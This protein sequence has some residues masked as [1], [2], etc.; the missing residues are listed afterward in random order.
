M[1]SAS[2][3]FAIA[4]HGPVTAATLRDRLAMPPINAKIEVNLRL[5]EM[6]STVTKGSRLQ[7]WVRLTNN[8][9]I[10]LRSSMPN[11][12]HLSYHCYSER[13][14]E[15]QQLVAFEGI[16]STFATVKAGSADDLEMHLIAPVIEG[17]FLFRITLVQEWVAWFDIPPQSAFVDGWLDVVAN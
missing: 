5:L 15:G 11:P 9:G 8:S 10:D 6:P 2:D 14:L 12:I 1:R 7:A 4:S 13:H 16:R 3:L 17:R